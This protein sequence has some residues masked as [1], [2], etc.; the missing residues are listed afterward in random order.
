MQFG[1]NLSFVSRS[2]A[3]CALQSGAFYTAFLHRVFRTTSCTAVYVAL[4]RF[5]RVSRAAVYVALRRV[6]RTTS[7]GQMTVELAVTIPVIM[8]VLAIMIN[9]MVYLDVSIRFDRLAAEAVRIEATSP[10]YGS[11]GTTARAD[12]VR[13][14]LQNQF[15]DETHFVRIEVRAYAGTDAGTGEQG[16]S[17]GLGSIFS[18]IA[19]LETYECT[20]RYSPWGFNNSFFGVNFFELT[21]TRRYTIDPF[22]PAVIA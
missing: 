20:L 15:A 5:S 13:S 21:H 4:R 18:F 11:Y 12:K 16:S 14:L 10:G 2:R 6:F 8:A 17:T 22:R 1:S 7:H 9:T 3:F 19:G